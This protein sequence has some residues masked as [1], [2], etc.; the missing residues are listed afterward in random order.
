MW[1][2]MHFY[3]ESYLSGSEARKN[4]PAGGMGS[5]RLPETEGEQASVSERA[6]SVYCKVLSQLRE[7]LPAWRILS[8]KFP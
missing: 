5:Q 8:G 2:L 1:N 3:P 7:S 4:T 6:S